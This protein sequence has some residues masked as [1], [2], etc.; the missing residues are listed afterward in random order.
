MAASPAPPAFRQRLPA[1][2]VM[3]FEP[4]ADALRHEVTAFYRERGEPLS[5]LA[6]HNTLET[7]SGLVMRRGRPLVRF[8]VGDDRRGDALAGLDLVDV[9]CG[10]GALSVL[11][12]AYGAQV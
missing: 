5:G 12:A 8:L 7:N 10:F 6:G 4:I 3:D 11:C 2:A 9:G 1:G